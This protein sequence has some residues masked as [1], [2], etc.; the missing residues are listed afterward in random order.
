MI[1]EGL[2]READERA[3]VESE[4]DCGVNRHDEKIVNQLVNTFLDLFLLLLDFSVLGC[5]GD[6]GKN[7]NHYDI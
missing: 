3:R 4:K 1:H 7:Y 6:Y 5:F 2:N